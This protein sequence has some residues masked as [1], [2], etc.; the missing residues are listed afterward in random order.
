M[1]VRNLHH[2]N[3]NDDD[4][5]Y[6]S[7]SKATTTKTTT[8]TNVAECDAQPEHKQEQQQQQQIAPTVSQSPPLLQP[9][10][11]SFTALALSA[12]VTPVR[13]RRRVLSSL[14]NDDNDDDNNTK[15]NNDHPETV[16]HTDENDAHDGPAVP[17]ADISSRQP[18]SLHE[19]IQQQLPPQP[20]RTREE[21]TNNNNTDDKRRINQSTSL[22]SSSSSSS[23]S[24]SQI[25]K[26]SS[27]LQPYD[28]YFQHHHTLRPGGG[29]GRRRRPWPWVSIRN[30]LERRRLRRQQQR[31]LRQQQ[32]RNSS[33]PERVTPWLIPAHHPWK[34]VWDIGTVLV[35]LLNAYLTHVAIR[36]RQFSTNASWRGL[37]DLWFV[38]DMLLNFVSQQQVTPQRLLTSVQSV[39]ASY[40]TS[41]FVVDLI[42]LLPV[43]V[44]YMQ[45]I[46]ERQN[47]RNLF[48]KSFFRTRAVM[49]VMKWLRLY[50]WEWLG[51]L[52]QTTH[53]VGYGRHR[54]VRTMI[55]YIPKYI[56][57]IKTMKAMVAIRFLRLIHFVR[58]LW[59]YYRYAASTAGSMS[60][61]QQQNQYWC[62]GSSSNQTTTSLTT[63]TTMT[64]ASTRAEN[65][66]ALRFVFVPRQP[67]TYQKDFVEE[68]CHHQHEDPLWLARQHHW[69]AYDTKDDPDDDHD[70][71]DDGGDQFY[72]YQHYYDGDEDERVDDDDYD[73]WEWEPHPPSLRQRRHRQQQEQQSSGPTRPFLWRR[74]ATSVDEYPT[75]RGR[76]GMTL[77]PAT[78]TTV[79]YRYDHHH[80]DDGDPY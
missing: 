12:L 50:H 37:C 40:L 32:Q 11:S 35:A 65:D 7:W 41:W 49:K 79:T 73:E 6:L 3:D 19:K 72:Y 53:K 75:P 59:N 71:D 33:Q 45:P 23:I 14:Y 22:S 4:Y 29:G 16:E 78:T 5:E 20:Q 36:D 76:P 24:S 39:W 66:D 52:A 34:T 69:H 46:I 51:Q 55:K 8:E 70:D 61:H 9:H 42:A 43:E 38:C 18:T 2:E 64:A 57:F 31:L 21:P 44:W 10:P 28:Y 74:A 48:T 77:P 25:W 17:F 54:L 58:R 62:G 26:P 15:N 63:A 47:R 56:L 13:W 30:T 27:S 60:K 80:D 68:S 1:T 67:P